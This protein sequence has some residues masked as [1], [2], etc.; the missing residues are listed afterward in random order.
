MDAIAGFSDNLL[1]L[2]S[3][4]IAGTDPNTQ[5]AVWKSRRGWVD[6]CETWI[7]C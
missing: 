6:Q 2:G 5:D 4:A 7:P 1:L 3:K